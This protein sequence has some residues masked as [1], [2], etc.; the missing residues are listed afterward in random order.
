METDE[1]VLRFFNPI[2]SFVEQQTELGNSI[3]IHCLAGAHRAG[4]TGV[5]WLMFA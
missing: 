3:L 1:G 4:T 5:S 2:F